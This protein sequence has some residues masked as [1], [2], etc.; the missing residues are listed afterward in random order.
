[1]TETDLG[2]DFFTHVKV[3]L[4]ARVWMQKVDRADRVLVLMHG[5]QQVASRMLEKV[6]RVFGSEVYIVAVEAPF[7][8]PLRKNDG[9]FEPGYSWY[10]YDLDRKRAVI[11]FSASVGFMKSV[12]QE[13]NLGDRPLTLMGFSQ[14]GYASLAVAHQVSQIDHVIG[15]GCQFRPD[16][17]G[18]SDLGVLQCRVDAV[19][20]E[21][22]DIVDFDLAKKY[23]AELKG[24]GVEGEF[25][26][27][28]GVG[29]RLDDRILNEALR[30]YRA[31]KNGGPHGV[32]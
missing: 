17:V 1:M 15:L 10:F 5:Y 16:R 31:K 13:L 19:H 18:G 4:P 14:G 8:V 6:K 3:D 20:G 28:P 24:H 32:V 27:V 2:A 29:H 25:I 23:F 11:D 22:D 26:A 21:L 7:P 12:L 9:S 30:L